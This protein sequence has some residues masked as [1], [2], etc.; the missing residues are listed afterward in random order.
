[1]FRPTKVEQTK[2]KGLIMF[3]TQNNLF[4]SFNK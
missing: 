3:W 2:H 1:M 4:A